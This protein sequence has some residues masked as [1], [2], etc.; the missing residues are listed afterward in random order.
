MQIKKI[1]GKEKLKY[2]TLLLLADEQWNMVE[3]YLERGEMY[4]LSK[5]N[6]V[7]GSCIITDEGNG[8][9]ELKSLAVYPTYHHQG[10]GKYLVNFVLQHYKNLGH[11]LYVGTGASPITL[12][13]Y[14]HCGFKYSHSIKNFFTD[15]YLEPIYEAGV[16][17]VDMIYLKQKL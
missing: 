8:N 11:T 7:I 4:I 9:F 5:G 3:K 6:A 1:Q 14:K 15:N 2:K 12:N 16:K 13:F 10:H 17:I